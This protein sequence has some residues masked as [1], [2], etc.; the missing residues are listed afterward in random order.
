MCST[1]YPREGISDVLARGS[2]IPVLT[3]ASEVADIVAPVDRDKIIVVG[4]IHEVPQPKVNIPR[5]GH[6]KEVLHRSAGTTS[7]ALRSCL[8]KK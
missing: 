4:D 8:A 6:I 2:I 5:I 1:P 3:V 7:H